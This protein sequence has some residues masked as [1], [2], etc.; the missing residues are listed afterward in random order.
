[1]SDFAKFYALLKK[2]PYADKE[3]IVSTY[4]GDVT[5]SL[6]EFKKCNPTG[7]RWMLTDLENKTAGIETKKPQKSTDEP[8]KRRFRSLILRAMQD[9]G[10]TVKDRD[11]S[12]VNAF[13]ER[14]AGVGK[15]LSNMSL[16]E[17]KT[18]NAQVHKLLDWYI[19]KKLAAMALAIMN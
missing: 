8:Q 3:T 10:V 16:D 14:Y 17:L 2:L 13:V 5:R 18:F 11:W 19:K 6:R 15:S 4:S 12:D 9:Q 1:M 7:F